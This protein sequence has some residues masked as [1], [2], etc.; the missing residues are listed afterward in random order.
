MLKADPTLFARVSRIVATSDSI[1]EVLQHLL[2]EAVQACDADRGFLAIADHDRGE[3]DVRY[4]AGSGWT[5][6]KRLGRLKV[7]EETGG[8]I[9][10]RVAATG[11]LYRSSNV[12]EDPYY[13]MS[14]EDVR[15]EIAVP[16]IDKDQRTRGVL[17]IESISPW[18]LT[19]KSFSSISIFNI[20]F[21]SKTALSTSRA[22]GILM[23]I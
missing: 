18:L 23:V 13:I 6:E 5:E 16:M 4:T 1:D 15:S 12:L 22:S 9:T 3:L 2:E 7:S 20:L 11:T 21:V 8:G 19:V 10:S 14:F 17:N